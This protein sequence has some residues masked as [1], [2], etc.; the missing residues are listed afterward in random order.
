MPETEEASLIFCYD[1]LATFGATADVPA[2]HFDI[3]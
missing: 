3:A 2:C 1:G